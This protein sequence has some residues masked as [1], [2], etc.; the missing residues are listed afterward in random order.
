MRSAGARSRSP[1]RCCERPRSTPPVRTLAKEP[2]RRPRRSSRPPVATGLITRADVEAYA[3]R[4]GMRRPTDLGRRS[5]LPASRPGGRR[6]ADHAHPIRGVRKH[7][8]AGDGAQRLHRAA[9]DD[10]PHRRR[11][12][13]DGARSRRCARDRA[14]EGH[15]IGVLAVAAKAVCLALG[16]P[17]RAQLAWDDDAGEIVQHHYVNLGIAAAT[18]RGLVVPNIRDARRS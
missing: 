1:T 12:A 4:V 17:P 14:L 2:G 10:V 18:E 13:D 5:R 15:R 3:Q 6:L 7:T 8:A 11:H 9:R 16:A